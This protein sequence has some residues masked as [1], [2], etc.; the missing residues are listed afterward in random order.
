MTVSS[1]G[2]SSGV[3]GASGMSPD[4][5]MAFCGQILGDLDA[6]LTAKMKTMQGR[7][8]RA[9]RLNRKI[10][11]LQALKTECGERG[12][13]DA[14]VV[15]AANSPKASRQEDARR[16][17]ELCAEYGF[18]PADLP[19]QGKWHDRVQ[20]I[21]TEQL[22]SAIEN[23]N[24]ELHNLTDGNQMEMIEIQDLVQRRST[25]VGMATQMMNSEHETHKQI[26]GNLR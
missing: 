14:I 2:S 6:S 5:I 8:E 25:I 22:T 16:F 7:G 19:V 18:D 15:N 3:P 10:A 24:T 23:L 4:M 21:S 26:V 11:L 9:D 12:S 13:P 17:S 1:I 20:A